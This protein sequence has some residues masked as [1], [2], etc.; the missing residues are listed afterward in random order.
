MSRSICVILE[1]ISRVKVTHITTLERGYR[2]ADLEIKLSFD[3]EQYFIEE[4]WLDDTIDFY[5]IAERYNFL[6]ELL[7]EA[8]TQLKKGKELASLQDKITALEFETSLY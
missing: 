6:D 4:A 1:G 3:G 8:L 2:K 7:E 5:T